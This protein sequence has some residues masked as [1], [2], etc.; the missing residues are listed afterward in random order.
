VT[1]G[2]PLTRREAQKLRKEKKRLAEATKNLR[3]FYRKLELAELQER[4]SKK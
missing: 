4:E 2:K 3:E 1:T